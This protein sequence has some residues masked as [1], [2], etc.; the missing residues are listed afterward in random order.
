MTPRLREKYQKEVAPALLQRFGYK[1][2]MQIPRVE[3]VVVNM[4]VSDAVADAKAIDAAMNDLMI[5]TGQKPLLTRAKNSIAAFKLRKGMPIGCKVTLRGD[6]MYYFLDKLFNVALPRIRDFRGV[7]PDGFDGRGN[8]N[9]G[10]KEQ[11]IF[12]EISYDQIDK[13]RGMDIAIVTTAP[14]DEEAAELLKG[15]G[16]PFQVEK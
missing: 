16:M 3:K 2:P 7:S 10:I 11:T 14:T 9:L 5:I 4:G 6:R 13:I 8:Y 1:S 12:P 15:L